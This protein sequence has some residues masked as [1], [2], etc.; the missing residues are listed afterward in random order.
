MSSQ[1]SRR[2]VLYLVTR[3]PAATETFVVNE[4]LALRER[5]QMRLVALRRSGEVPVHP[6]AEAVLPAVRFPGVAS[7]GTIAANVGCLVRRPRAYLSTL[8]AVVRGGLRFSVTAAATETVVFLKAVAV[9]RAAQREGVDHVHAH[10]ASHPATAAWVVHRLTGIPFSF[11]AHANDLF[12][13]PVLLDRK[14]VDA[15]FA[16]AISEYNRRVLLERSPAARVEVVHCGVD[17]DANAW[18][19]LGERA[20]DR[21]VCVA[22]LLPK[23]GHADLIDALAAL[24]ER[25]PDVV[26]ELVG[27]G[28]ERDR[29]LRRARE[30]GVD[31]RVSL[32]GAQSSGEVRATLAQARAFALPSIRLPSGRMEGIPVALMEA[33]A[34]GVPV[35]A[36]R[37]SGIPELVKDGVTGLLVEPHDPAGLAAALER[38]LADD[39]L[40]AQLA[41]AARAL[42]ERS[43]SLPVEAQRLGDLFAES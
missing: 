31:R 25:R 26:L 34:S 20:P 15:R 9:A 1:G 7:P 5:F 37:L 19:G 32:L 16:I 42:V 40:A 38:L 2:V 41:Q 33:M 30:R 13:A 24:A 3:F 6:E 27:E 29:I 17:V 14:G 12:V 43:F 8:A 28:P 36:T 11:T 23:K 10:F 4:W 22:S 18:R 35:V 39:A 21:V